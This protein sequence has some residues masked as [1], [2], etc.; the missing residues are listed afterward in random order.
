M[1]S[2]ADRSDWITGIATVPTMLGILTFALFPFA[3]PGLILAIAAAVLLAL[4]LIVLGAIA[5]LVRGVWIGMRAAG[6]GLARARAEWTV[7]DA[8]PRHHV[9]GD[10]HERA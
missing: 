6:R 9:E 7:R 4:P 3:L 1:D 10:L 8:L 5:A 2:S